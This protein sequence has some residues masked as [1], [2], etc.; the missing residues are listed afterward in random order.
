MPQA[1][2]SPFHLHLDDQEYW[3]TASTVGH[4]H[5]F[6]TDAKRSVLR[7]VLKQVAREPGIHL[8]AWALLPNHYHVLVRLDEGK[9]LGR[10]LNT[11]HGR[12]SNLV[13]RLDGTRG[14]KVWYQYWDRCI[15]NEGDFYT[16]FNY[17]HHNPVKH[18]YASQ[19]EDYAFSS[20]QYYV[21]RF[22]EEWLQSAWEKFPILDFTP[23][24]GDGD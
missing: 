24:E 23:T 3:L 6:D 21:R 8:R 12:S 2:F 5:V 16:R 13:N 15:R 14:R 1:Y 4:V 9:R 11:L 19:P 17:I 18:G 7:S 20:Y 10:V 22:G